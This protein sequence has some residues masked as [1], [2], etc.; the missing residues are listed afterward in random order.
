MAPT[1]PPLSWELVAGPFVTGGTSVALVTA[2][3]QD[4]EDNGWMVL[5]EPLAGQVQ[6]YRQP[7]PAAVSSWTSV[8]TITNGG[9]GT[10]TNGFGTALDLARLSSSSSSSSTRMG[11]LV[12]APQTP[13]VNNVAEFGSVAYYELD[14]GAAALGGSSSWTRVGSI[15]TP[16]S[17]VFHAGGEF[18]AAVSLSAS[19]GAPERPRFVVAAPQSGGT[20]LSQ[21]KAGKIYTYQ[22]NE[23]VGDWELATDEPLVGTA[24]SRLGSSVAL[25]RTGERLVAGAPTAAQGNGSLV[26]YDWKQETRQWDTLETILGGPDEALG[27]SVTFLT[28]SGTVLA[29]GAPTSN[30]T[31]G[32]IRVYQRLDEDHGGGLEKL[33]SDLVGTEPGQFVGRTL[34]GTQWSSSQQQEWTLVVAFGTDTGS[35]HVYYYSTSDQDWVPVAAVAPEPPSMGSAIVSLALSDTADTVVVGLANQQTQVYQ[36]Q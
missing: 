25:S 12:G 24:G 7:Q 33:G 34:C 13:D 3:G 18:G 1:T 5:G 16:P 29:V 11:L 26:Y 4:E 9:G 30:A 23:A 2:G 8:A 22:Y 15:Q 6:V 27:T 19:P 21:T 36:L 10:T 20:S 14:T 35:F 31:H 32:A 17:I 28:D